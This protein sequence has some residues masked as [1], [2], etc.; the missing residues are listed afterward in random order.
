MTENRG[1]NQVTNNLVW[2]RLTAF[3]PHLI[4]ALILSL[5]ALLPADAQQ[6]LPAGP[7]IGERPGRQLV[8][9]EIATNAPLLAVLGDLPELGS[10]VVSQALR[11]VRDNAASPWRLTVS[12]PVNR[13]FTYRF[14]RGSV[15]LGEVLT[16]ETVAVRSGLGGNLLFCHAPNDAARLHWRQDDGEFHSAPL[17]RIGEGRTPEESLWRSAVAGEAG[18]PWEFFIASEDEAFRDPPTGAYHTPLNAPFLQDGELFTYRPAAVVGP[19]RRDYETNAP[20]SLSSTHLANEVRHY[21]VLL[22]RGYDEQPNRRYP[23]IYFH[24]GQTMWETSPFYQAGRNVIDP[25]GMELAALVRQGIVGEMIVVGVD[26]TLNRTANYRP[27]ITDGVDLSR[28]Y[29]AFLIEELKP[30]I[31][32]RYRTLPD[33]NYTA[34]Y[35]FGGIVALFLGWDHPEVFRG[36]GSWSGS[37]YTSSSIMPRRVR[38]EPSR[39]IRIYLDSGEDARQENLELRNM[40]LRKQPAYSLEGS[41]RHVYA[42]GQQHVTE[43]FVRRLPDMMSFLYPATE[44]E[45][46]L[47]PVLTAVRHQ[48]LLTLG[49]P[50]LYSDW[51]LESAPAF[52]GPWSPVTA[53]PEVNEGQVQQ[54]VA[55]GDDAGFFRL[56][57]P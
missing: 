38:D 41:L 28:Q 52:T 30:L 26:A 35:S 19:S 42:P 9:F 54:Q 22:P 50:A 17:Q 5:G 55:A 32:A 37:F 34:G 57:Q 43:H 33:V 44:S 8:K 47:L 48:A 25:D 51:V 7:A 29:A 3:N 27:G 24:D 40:L 15:P 18:R 21:R 46:E 10:N 13:R 53:A 56:R 49:R 14:H 11:M 4:P 1:E 20:P 36:I 39:P 31:D 16:G 2:A 6:L 45:G 23:V 12:L